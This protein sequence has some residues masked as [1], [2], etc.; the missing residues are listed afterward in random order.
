MPDSGLFDVV[1]SKFGYISDTLQAVMVNGQITYL[2]ATLD[3]DNSL[4][5]FRLSRFN[6]IKFQSNCKIHL[7]YMV[8]N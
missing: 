8:E 1:F 4:P 7:H 6:C 2:D 5:I 3:I